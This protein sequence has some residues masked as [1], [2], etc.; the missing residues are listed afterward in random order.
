[1]EN[2]RKLLPPGILYRPERRFPKRADGTTSL[3]VKKTIHYHGARDSVDDLADD[4]LV[5]WR[6]G[7]PTCVFV[8]RK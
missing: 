8:D 2:S 6:A 3:L 4:L 7:P 5:H 1:M